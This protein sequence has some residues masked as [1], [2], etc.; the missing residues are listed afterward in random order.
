MDKIVKWYSSP[1]K[2]PNDISEYKELDLV[3]GQ[4]LKIP[5]R[6][7][8]FHTDRLLFVHVND[9]QRIFEINSNESLK[10]K[11]IMLRNSFEEEDK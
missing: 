11:D 9:Y 1:E 6:S 8:D 3:H 4:W 7:C 5:T 10:D 2:F